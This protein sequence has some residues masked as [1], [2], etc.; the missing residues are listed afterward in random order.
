MNE[1]GQPSEDENPAKEPK[2][3]PG[4]VEDLKPPEREASKVK[5]GVYKIHI[6]RQ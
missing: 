6:H 4:R 5:G 2:L 3:A 1:P